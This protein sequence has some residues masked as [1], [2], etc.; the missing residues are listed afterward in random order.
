MV[1]SAYF[2]ITHCSCNSTHYPLGFSRYSDFKIKEVQV[3]ERYGYTFNVL[4]VGQGI[5]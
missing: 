2:I 5:S 4:N 1:D 3:L